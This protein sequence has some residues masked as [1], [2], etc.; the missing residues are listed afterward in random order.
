MH[1]DN[2]PK[3]SLYIFTLAMFL[4]SSCISEPEPP[5]PPDEM[6]SILMDIHLAEAYSMMVTDSTHYLREKDKDSLA[7]F[8]N[9]ILSHYKLSKDEFIDIVDWY[10]HHPEQMDSVYANMITEMSKLEAKYP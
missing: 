10:R 6:K 8:Y 3:K 4:L 1:C 2:I 5:L 9:D 7:V